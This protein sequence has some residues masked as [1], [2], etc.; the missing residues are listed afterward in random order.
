MNASS[1]NNTQLSW[2]VCIDHGYA[3]QMLFGAAQALCFLLGTPALV[4]CLWLCLSGSLCGGVKPT[5]IFPVNL[6][7]VELVFCVECLL[8]VISYLLIW[9]STMLRQAVYFLYIVSWT[10]RPLLQSCICVE[11]YLAVAQPVTFLKYRLRRYRVVCSTIVW[12]LSLTHACFPIALIG[13]KK[14]AAHVLISVY[15][16]G[17]VVIS[18]CCFFILRVLKQPGPGEVEGGRGGEK[19]Q[20][21]TDPH[22]MRAFGIILSKLVIILTCSILVVVGW[23]TLSSSLEITCNVFPMLMIVNIFSVLVSPLMH[24]YREGRLSCRR[25][26]ETR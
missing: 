16:L 17:V 26:P 10:C 21:M 18:L 25:G 22:K 9:N 20:G 6:F 5:Q 12:V 7:V 13:F 3:V 2:Y 8:E 15:C 4:W 24:L 1:G 23:A 14:T 11:R 19:K